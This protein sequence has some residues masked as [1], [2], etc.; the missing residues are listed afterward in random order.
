[1]SKARRPSLASVFSSSAYGMILLAM[2][3]V[4]NVS[5]VQAFRQISLPICA[6]A[7]VIAA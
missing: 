1:M 5:L 3:M 6:V 7:G 4:T 2:P